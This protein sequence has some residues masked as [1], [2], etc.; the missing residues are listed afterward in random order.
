MFLSL[1][2]KRSIG[3]L[4]R[5][6]GE[7]PL[8]KYILV[9]AVVCFGFGIWIRVPNFMAPD[10]YS[11]L[12]QP[13]K[14]AG[15]F[16][17]EPGLESLQRAATDGRALGATMYLYALVLVPVFIFILLTGNLGQ[18]VSLG[19]IQS[20]WALW[21]AAPSWFW[22]GAVLLGRAVVV[23]LA[24][25]AVYLVYR[26]GVRIRNR[27][28]GR[29]AAV[30]LTLSFGFVQSTRT[31]NE[32]VPMIVLL[33]LTLL[34]CLRY[35]DSGAR[36][37]FLLACFT[38]GLAVA[39]KLTG[40][41]AVL[42]VG[43]SYLLRARTAEN[44]RAAL[45]DPTT[46]GAGLLVGAATIYVGFPSVLLGGPGELLTRVTFSSGEK[47]AGPGGL[48][49]GIEFYLLRGYLGSFGLPLLLGVLVGVGATLRGLLPDTDE[50]ENA[51]ALVMVPVV[52]TLLVFVNWQYVRIHHLLPTLPPL[53][54]LGALGLD[55]LRNRWTSG[56]RVAVAV[57]LVTSLLFT[58]VGNLQATSDP[59]DG[60]TEW[61]RTNTDE[62]ATVEV[63]EDSIADVAAV[64]GR[65]IQHF[66]YQ[67]ENATYEGDLVL[68]ERAYTNW[69]VGMPERRPDYIQ[70]TGAE[71]QYTTPGHPDA[72]QYPRRGKYVQGLLD[73]AYNYTVVAQ[74]GRQQTR[75]S[76]S[77]ELL[78]AGVEPTVEKRESTVIILAR[79]NATA[80]VQ[81]HHPS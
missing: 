44:P 28:T 12:I 54:L 20:R 31:I 18:F 15:R 72:E 24:V 59:R 38:A 55:R 36:R 57:L 42:V 58:A 56:V 46:L 71:L 40:G 78:G 41:S 65:E 68:N 6:I 11:R 32:D 33:L 21:Q 4:R 74:F 7:D 45:V 16:V 1:V 23:L 10:E 76:P 48:A 26:L 53:L 52:V 49:S 30:G 35:L 29:A 17:A 81:R 22:T 50:S 13:M 25:V 8:L 63:Y 61:L 3:T 39:F 75:Q 66:D 70:L 9:L 2:K 69:M 80:S 67:E 60:A 79:E 64:H 14:I 47:T 51:V 43:A 27:W 37:T 73:G 34:L 5:D 62:N 19:G 77:E